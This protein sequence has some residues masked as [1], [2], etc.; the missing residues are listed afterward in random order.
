MKTQ[1]SRDGR[2]IYVIR[3]PWHQIVAM[4]RVLCEDGRERTI[5]TREPDTFFT[6]PGRTHARGRT[7][8]GFVAYDDAAERFRFYATGKHRDLLTN[9]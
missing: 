8:T 7:V 3:E 9:N 6:C 2:A 5:Q 4:R 1:I